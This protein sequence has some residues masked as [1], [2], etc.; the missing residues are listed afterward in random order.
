MG[1][2]LAFTGRRDDFIRDL[3]RQRTYFQLFIAPRPPRFSR[4]VL[5]ALFTPTI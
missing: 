2:P 4:P 5:G 1:V 3:K